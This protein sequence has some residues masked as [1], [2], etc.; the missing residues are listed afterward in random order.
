MCDTVTNFSHGDGR[1]SSLKDIHLVDINGTMVRLVQRNFD[2]HFKSEPY[3]KARSGISG[4][5]RGVRDMAS[6]IMGGVGAMAG[7]MAGARAKESDPEE[8][9]CSDDASDDRMT[10][11][12]GSHDLHMEISD[13]EEKY[14]RNSA[15]SDHSRR[16]DDT[17]SASGVSPSSGHPGRLYPDLSDEGRASERDARRKYDKGTSAAKDHRMKSHATAAQ[18]G[19]TRLARNDDPNRHARKTSGAVAAKGDRSEKDDD[20]P[21]CMDKLT[22]PKELSRCKH[23]F[24]KACIDKCFMLKQECPVCRMVYGK[25]QGTQPKDGKMDVVV[26]PSKL[27]GFSCKTCVIDYSFRDGIQTVS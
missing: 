19:A 9:P 12:D 23:K 17:K 4:M 24:C 18:D 22:N 21:I 8:D 25:I 1:H 14:G 20:C 10:G 15:M 2:Q 6:N 26:I 16:R 7:A 3:I 13:D 5:I 27:P 11:Q